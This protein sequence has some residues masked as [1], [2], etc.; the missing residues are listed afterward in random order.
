MCG[1]C[2]FV[3]PN[4][5]H[6]FD[7]DKHIFKRENCNSCGLCAKE[8]FFDALEN[9]GE[10]KGVEEVLKEVLKDEVFYSTSGGGMTVSGGEPMYQPEFTYQLL[11]S[12]K[13]KGIHNCIETCGFASWENFDKIREFVDI[14]L[15]DW[16]ITDPEKHKEFTGVSNEV[17]LRNLR[18]LDENGSKIILRCPII[19]TINNNEEHFKGIADIANSLKNILEIN[20][21]P[22]HPLGSNKSEM[23]GKDYKLKD[24][25]FPTDETVQNWIATISAMTDIPVKKA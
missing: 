1:R 6:I 23:L 19:P 17:I 7:N 4:E 9:V 10:E 5:C 25:T 22:Y 3:C 2:S 18:M 21:E 15:F 16:K 24:L 12:A 13:E 20:I 8:C 14:F 11:K